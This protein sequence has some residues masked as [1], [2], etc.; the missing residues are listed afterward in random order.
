[1]QDEVKPGEAT[2]FGSIPT[3]NLCESTI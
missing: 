3:L 1:M 2:I